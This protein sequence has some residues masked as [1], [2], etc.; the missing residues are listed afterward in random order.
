MDRN[1]FGSPAII[2]VPRSS[3][4]GPHRKAQLSS[5]VRLG[6]ASTQP[7]RAAE[8]TRIQQ[9]STWCLKRAGTPERVPAMTRPGHGWQRSRRCLAGPLPLEKGA[10]SGRRFSTA[11]GGRETVDADLD[12]LSKRQVLPL[13]DELL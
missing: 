7:V 3:G 9:K 10:H 11:D 8:S 12:C 6:R 1:W 4:I 13:A 5:F 2:A